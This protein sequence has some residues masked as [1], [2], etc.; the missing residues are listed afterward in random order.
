MTARAARGRRPTRAELAARERRERANAHLER[1]RGRGPRRAPAGPLQ[2]AAVLSASVLL[3]FLLGSPLLA[4]A[5]RWLPG[6]GPTLGSLHVRGAARVSLAEVARATG[7]P[8]AAPLAGVDAETVANRVAQHP[9]IAEARALRLVGGD[10]LLDVVEREPLAVVPTQA[11]DYLIDATGTPFAPAAAGVGPLPR[12]RPAAPATANRPDPELARALALARRLPALGLELPREV[13]TS[14]A[15]DPTG[16]VLFPVHPPTR[17]VLGRDDPEAALARLALL[18]AAEL[19]EVAAAAQIDL[20]FADQAV[21]GAM[22][23]PKRAET[24]AAARGRAMP[25]NARPSG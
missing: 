20:R 6:V 18:L 22:P 7:L 8:P 17:V 16:F 14:P 24:A 1:V 19:P 2:V 21:L 4:G 25:S 23:A 15:G 13:A 3:G 10:L 9:W 5:Q 12:L 11:G